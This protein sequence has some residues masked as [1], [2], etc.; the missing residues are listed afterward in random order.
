[1]PQIGRL[2]ENG[3]L[4]H[5]NTVMTL[6]PYGTGLVYV[7]LVVKPMDG[8]RLTI[9]ETVIL[10]I[11]RLPP[12][13]QPAHGQPAARRTTRRANSG[14]KPSPYDEICILAIEVG[15]EALRA[16]LQPQNPVNVSGIREKSAAQIVLNLPKKAYSKNYKFGPLGLSF[17][18]GLGAPS[19]SPSLWLR[20][21]RGNASLAA[22]GALILRSK[23]WAHGQRPLYAPTTRPWPVVRLPPHTSKTT[24]Q[25]R[26]SK[27]TALQCECANCIS[28]ASF[29]E[30]SYSANLGATSRSAPD[31]VGLNA[32]SAEGAVGAY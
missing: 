5:G 3:L 22:C 17:E 9:T 24:E 12:S 6:Q 1:M 19:N 31:Q 8:V 27:A 15:N 14:V 7:Y 25:L 29:A 28:S 26:M 32:H 23:I 18:G 13:R 16:W 20:L 4:I 2:S 11:E 21:R 10:A 30:T